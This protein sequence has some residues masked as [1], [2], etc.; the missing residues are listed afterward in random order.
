MFDSIIEKEALKAY[1][2][3]SKGRKKEIGEQE[4]PVRFQKKFGRDV[5]NSSHR[6]CNF[7][8]GCE[9]TDEFE[10]GAL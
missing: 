10:G 8:E 4:Y 2:D 3:M 1:H 7:D 6:Y 5:R 9:N